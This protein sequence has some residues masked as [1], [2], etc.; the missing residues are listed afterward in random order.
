MDTSGLDPV[1]PLLGHAFTSNCWIMA[2]R[3]EKQGGEH[4]VWAGVL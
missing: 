4:W 1:D 2:E 3:P